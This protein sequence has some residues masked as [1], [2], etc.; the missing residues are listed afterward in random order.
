MQMTSP[1]EK[2]KN[3]D[4]T[5][6]GGMFY[7]VGYIV[8][9]F[10]DEGNAIKVRQDLLTGGYEEDDCTLHACKDVAA[11]ASHTLESRTGFL[12]LL[13]RADDLVRAHLDAAERG[14][15]FLMIYAPGDL[16]ASRALNVMRRVPFQFA[17]RYHRFAIESLH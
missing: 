14:A 17:H 11:A 10:A 8:A 2:K 16:D 12:A 5:D 13:G 9:G 3:R 6:L 7:P 4:M 15:T 1:D